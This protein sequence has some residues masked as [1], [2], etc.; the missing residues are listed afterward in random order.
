MKKLQRMV[1]ISVIDIIEQKLFEMSEKLFNVLLMDRTTKKNICWATDHYISYGSAY[2]PQEPITKDLITGRNTKIVQPRVSKRIEEQVKR[3]KDKA[4]VFTPSWVCNE[5]N[6][7]VDEAWFGRKDV[8]NVSKDQT[9]KATKERIIFPKDKN[10]RKY[11]DAKRLEISCGEAPYLV[12]RYDTV[13]GKEIAIE[14][15]I[16]LLDRKLRVVGENTQTSSEWLKAAQSAYMSIYGYEWQGD[17]LVLA[18]ESLLYTFIDYYKA[19][20]GKKPQLKSLQYI[21]SI[22]SWNIWQMDGLKGVIPGSCRRVQQTVQ[23][24]FDSST[25]IQ[26]CEGCQ[27]GDIL[28]H[29]GTYC[30]IKD[31]R[32]NKTLTFVSL[33][34]KGK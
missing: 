25:T 18:R 32:S 5:Q 6:N 16:G 30:K 33:L 12:S 15:R 2:Y 31:W 26:E 24:L 11:V 34:K 9:W 7:L 4:E 17:N 19:K 20:F 22:I 28:K 10:W 23:N 13:S 21:A 27:K 14:E 8:F 1:K 29:N 3:T